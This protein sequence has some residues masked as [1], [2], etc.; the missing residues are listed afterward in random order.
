MR[1]K[2]YSYANY[3]QEKKM[4]S[5][6]FRFILWSLLVSLVFSF[7]QAY[8][9][10]TVADSSLLT[11]KRIFASR[12]FVPQRFGPA[13]WRND[14]SKYVVLER[15]EE[16]NNGRDIVQYDAESGKKE[17]M[18]PATKMIPSGKSEPLRIAN[19]SFS[20]DEKS[21]LIFTNTKRVWRQNTRGDYWVLDLE[22]WK[23]TKLGG[24]VPPSSLMFAKLSPDGKRVAYVH[25]N[26]IYVENTADHT[27]TQFCQLPIL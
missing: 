24:D 15:S 22:N 16:I 18:V 7:N 23:L 8:S 10:D 1:F 26:N 3:K 2:I 25:E 5:K 11:V 27:I 17:I 21:L 14:G 6:S 13:H 12:D 20:R 4:Q 9:Q 19:Y